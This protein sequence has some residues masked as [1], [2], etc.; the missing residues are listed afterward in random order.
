MQEPD[1]DNVVKDT[2]GYRWKWDESNSG[3]TM[4]NFEHILAY[5]GLRWSVVEKE[6]GPLIIE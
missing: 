4:R 5:V 6:Y 3:W 2:D 1:H